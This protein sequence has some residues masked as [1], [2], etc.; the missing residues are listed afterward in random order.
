MA[1]ESE[2][3]LFAHPAS[4]RS[5]QGPSGGE[6]R[7][8]GRGSPGASLDREP[9]AS[10]MRPRSLDEFIGQEHIVGPGR[11]LRRAIQKD[12]LTSIIF[13]GPPG[14][15]K[16][17]L[18]RIIANTTRSA[19]IALNAVL[20]GVGEL[21][22]AIEKARRHYELY[23][24]KT[25][26]FVDEVHRWNRSQQDALLPW[27]ENGTVILVGA[28]TENP[29]FEV[30]R[31]LVSRSRVFLLRNLQDDDLLK[32]A[33]MTIADKERGYGGF[34]VK[35][36]AE[37]LEHLVRSSDGDARSLLNALELAIE[38]SVDAWPPD[39]GAEIEISLE[40]AE[41]SIQKRVV[42][43][44]KD[45]DYHY[46]AISAFIK[47]LRGSD[48]DAAL[49]WL[50]RMV[51]AGED[52]AFIF[53]R[54]LISA[55]EDVG[56]ADPAAI[57]VVSSC[58]QSFD[59][60]GL[61]EGQFHLSMAALYLATCPKSN[62]TMGYFDA[63]KAVE[64]EGAEV[65]DHLKDANRDAVGFGHGEGYKYPHAYQDH[66][67]AQQYLPDSI[68]R[69]VFYFPGSLG[70][71]GSRKVE[72]LE[73]REAQLSL[74]A[75]ELSEEGPGAKSPLSVWS[76]EGE[77]RKNWMA[78]AEGTA[79]RRLRLARNFLFDTLVCGRSDSILLIDPRKGF[80]A[81]E[82]AR[83]A[84]EGTVA[85]LLE[86]AAAQAQVEKLTADMPE[87]HRPLSAHRHD[88]A[89][90]GNADSW[91][92]RA[93]GFSGFDR[94]VVC[95]PLSS[96]AGSGEGPGDPDYWAP[97]E[98]ALAAS[99]KQGNTRVAFFD[100]HSAASS[101]LSELLK[102]N[103]PGGAA[104]G[105]EPE[106]DRLIAA[107]EAFEK[108]RGG[109]PALAPG[110]RSGTR[111]GAFENPKTLLGFF[112][113]HLK[114]AG[115]KGAPSLR[116]ER[117]SYERDLGETDIEAWLSAE[118]GYGAAL[119]AELGEKAAASLKKLLYGKAGN[120]QWPLFVSIVSA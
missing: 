60:I 92:E 67:V 33:A 44:D 59:R 23:S 16:T 10:R 79:S 36:E 80:Y 2:N 113:G 103:G 61:P 4:G 29:F 20:S 94:V 83:R 108:K 97:I 54:M 46:D 117:L 22:E 102:L 43:Y 99:R 93:F 88:S 9:L 45:G 37:A 86:D 87:L 66:W 1:R 118:S 115:I 112:S 17:T 76:K 24:L 31:A 71:E 85:V 116:F 68:K 39:A 11:L 41:E 27:V 110:A 107:L 77:R 69:S 12:Q 18:A 38:T 78:R 91:T 96:F 98:A 35:F 49:Y 19:F 81:L 56:L 32:I 15:G 58:A 95:E 73:R 119:R 30:N 7:G 106:T 52:P 89:L 21:R 42:L 101:R 90:Q 75:A 120:L 84:P 65:P 6:E 13:S 53:R 74:L 114:K 82:A 48:P 28:T 62:S 105:P 64:E 70:L 57:Q 50:A 8:A 5:G 47:S 72:V 111:P 3:P 40:T 26:L 25:I 55:A 51:Y 100:I 104:L 14:T 34:R 109:G 63:L